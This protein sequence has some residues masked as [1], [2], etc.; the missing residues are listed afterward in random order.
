MTVLIRELTEA[1]LDDVVEPALRAW[2]PVFESFRGVLGAEIYDR[3]YPD[4]H[5]SQA[6]DVAGV[7][8]GYPETT[9]VAESAGQPVGFI[10]VILDRPAHSADIEMLAV[11]PAH[12]R[13]GI[14]AALMDFAFTRMRA[15]GTRVVAVG[16]GGD[17]GHAPARAAYESVGFRPLPLVR[18][19][20]AL[21]P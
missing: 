7:C 14:A 1:D 6:R 2:S 8:R 20:R 13:R 9:W 18:Y 16:T 19:Y 5:T 11:D 21:E 12:Q 17:P 4:W 3:V 10:V 15:A